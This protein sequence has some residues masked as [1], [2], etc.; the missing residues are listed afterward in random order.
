VIDLLT[1]PFFQNALL[2]ALLVSIAIGAIGTLVAI[3]RLVFLS[4]GIAHAAYGGV[5]LAFFVGISPL[6]GAAAAG[7]AA[8]ALMAWISFYQRHR[9]DTLIGVIWAV[10]MALGVLFVD[11]T[12]GYSAD[13]MSYLFGSILAV[14]RMDLI[15]MALLD[16]V[17]VVCV[18]LFYRPLVAV[19][20]DE[21]FA[22]TRGLPVQAL[23]LLLLVLAALMIVIAIRVV[24]L[25]LVMALLTI[26]TY[27][28]ERMS[29]T[30]VGMMI[31]SGL[32]ALGFTVLGL[33]F[34]WWLNLSSGAA[35]I[36]TAALGMGLFSL[37]ARL[38]S[39]T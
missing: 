8:A 24:G 6:F 14:D 20:F 12:P 1:L 10:G 21:A 2:A 19:S 17:I 27:L 7:V 29:H 37:Y 4:G 18:A 28:A 31:L 36:F 23:Y 3:N 30:L 25:M 39:S 34:S 22:R 38:R 16:L 15:F 11:L 35:I 13:L 33:G 5:G 32:L 26:P 9:S